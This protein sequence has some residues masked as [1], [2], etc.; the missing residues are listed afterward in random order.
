MRLS[1]IMA[2][3]TA[4]V[5]AAASND[6]VRH[7]FR[8]SLI[9]AAVVLTE[10]FAHRAIERIVRRAITSEHFNSPEAERKREDTLIGIFDGTMRVIAWSIATFFFLTELGVSVAPFITVAGT[11]GLAISIGGQHVTRDV[12][13]GICITFEDQYHVDDRVCINTITGVV[14]DMTLRVTVI[15]DEHGA[16]HYVQHGLITAVA[17]F[18]DSHKSTPTQTA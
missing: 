13:A 14:T 3:L 5:T 4:F 15:R 7:G 6:I 11:L 9:V 2:D 1:T 12:L 17:N 8:I 18:R 16:T 10:R